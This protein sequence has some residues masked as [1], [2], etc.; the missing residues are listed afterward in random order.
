MKILVTGP[1]GFVGNY[2]MRAIPEAVTVPG[3]RGTE[4]EI[5]RKFADADA[6]IHTAAVSSMPECEKDPEGSY[7]ANVLLPVWIAEAAPQAKLVFFSSDQVYNGCSGEGPYSEEITCPVNVYAR[8]KLEMEQ[9]VAAI[10][11]DAVFLRAAWMYDRSHGFP[12]VM[13]A[14]EGVS[15]APKQYRGLTWVQEVADN[16]RKPLALPGGAYNFGSE[17]SVPMLVLQKEALRLLG[18]DCPVIEGE[19]R[20]NLWMNTAKAQSCGICFSDTLDG[21]RN[22]LTEMAQ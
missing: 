7:R 21:I 9:R 17:C 12:A 16:I 5:K 1:N 8:E 19:K 6:V 11:P 22:C 20:Q 3:L 14:C 18:K 4:A 13:R 10:S 15:T 2:I